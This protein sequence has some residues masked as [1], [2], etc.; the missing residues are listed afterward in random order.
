MPTRL[1]VIDLISRLIVRFLSPKCQGLLPTSPTTNYMPLYSS[2][3]AEDEDDDDK[4]VHHRH[5]HHH[6]QDQ[7]RTQAITS[8]QAGVENC[9]GSIHH[10]ETSGD[11]T[12]PLVDD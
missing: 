11:M 12:K 7:V 3:T 5:R 4:M 6:H 10:F 2:D 1:F 9:D 8:G